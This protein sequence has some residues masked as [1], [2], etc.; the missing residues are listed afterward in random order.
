MVLNPVTHHLKIIGVFL[1]AD[2]SSVCVDAG[3][4]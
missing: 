4:R 1:N 3:D 2:V